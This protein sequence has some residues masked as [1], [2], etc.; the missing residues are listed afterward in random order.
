MLEKCGSDSRCYGYIS[1]FGTVRV[2]IIGWETLS[3]ILIKSQ[4]RERKVKNWFRENVILFMTWVWNV[5]HF[6]QWNFRMNE[7]SASKIFGWL[8]IYYDFNWLKFS[9]SFMD[10]KSQFL[11]VMVAY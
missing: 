11:L 7:I 2:L 4:I 3:H 1:V 6:T 5:L 10:L 9:F 8:L